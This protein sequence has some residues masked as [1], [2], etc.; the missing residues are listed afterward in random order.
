MLL[1]E[2]LSRRWLVKGVASM[3]PRG[4]DVSSCG[5]HVGVRAVGCGDTTRAGSR[6]VGR[7][8]RPLEAGEDEE[9]Q[10]DDGLACSLTHVWSH[11]HVS[12]SAGVAKP[13]CKTTLENFLNGFV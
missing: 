9:S 5:L 1:L 6:T 3:V 7:G 8:E 2:V 12:V 11:A 13:R 10:A 4:E